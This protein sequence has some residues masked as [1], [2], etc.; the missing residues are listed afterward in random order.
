M[1][2]IE[3]KGEVTLAEAAEPGDLAQAEERDAGASNDASK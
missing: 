3:A 2:A 1:E